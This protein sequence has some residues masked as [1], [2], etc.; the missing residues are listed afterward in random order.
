MA[1]NYSLLLIL[2]AV[3]PSCGATNKLCG[4]WVQVQVNQSSA[5]LA[6]YDG[7]AGYIEAPGTHTPADTPMMLIYGCRNDQNPEQ[8]LN[9]PRTAWD[10]LTLFQKTAVFIFSQG[11]WQEWDE[12]PDVDTQIYGTTCSSAVQAIWFYG[13]CLLS[14]T[15]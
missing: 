9:V 1:V 14:C 6:R 3:L 7:C 15:L 2:V 10:K 11:E 13:G 5:P 12:I 4:Q 8:T